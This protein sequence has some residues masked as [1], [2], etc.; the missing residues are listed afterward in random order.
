M[1]GVVL[2]L[3]GGIGVLYVLSIA[4][5]SEYELKLTQ[6]VLTYSV[7]ILVMIGVSLVVSWAVAGK[8][9]NIDMVEALKGA[10]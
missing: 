6:G 10:E 3:P 7:S 8:N 2:G 4:L 1:I 9:K 5:A